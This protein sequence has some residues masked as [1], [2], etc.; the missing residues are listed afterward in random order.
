MPQRK[1]LVPL[2]GAAVVLL[3]IGFFTGAVGA[4][5]LGRDEPFLAVPE[6][7][8]APQAVFEI[9]GF[10]VTNTLLSAWLT[11]EA[12]DGTRATASGRSAELAPDVPPDLLLRYQRLVEGRGGKG[13]ARAVDCS[14]EECHVGIRRQVWVELITEWKIAACPGCQRLL[15]RDENTGSTPTAP[16]G[17]SASAAGEPT[18]GS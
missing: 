9:G 11:S 18:T 6:I 7:H 13:M 1:V 16:A 17:P 15:Y 2:L 3:G 5:L 10:A 14:C 8:L 4:A 12:L